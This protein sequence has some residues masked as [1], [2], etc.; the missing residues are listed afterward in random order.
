MTRSFVEYEKNANGWRYVKT[1]QVSVPSKPFGRTELA[2]GQH[3]EASAHTCDRCS[4]KKKV[5]K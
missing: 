5:R 3:V 2:L 4:P 1:I